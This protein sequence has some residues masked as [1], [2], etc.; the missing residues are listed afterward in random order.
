MDGLVSGPP[1]LLL[2]I[3]LLVI[4]LAYL[5]TP[6]RASPPRAAASARGRYV[7][8]DPE[9]PCTA[10]LLHHYHLGMHLI[11]L[12]PDPLTLRLDP[13]RFVLRAVLLLLLR[14][15]PFSVVL[16]LCIDCPAD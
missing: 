4:K 11:F 10:A 5:F 8:W 14:S 3:L 13:P 9:W 15:A 2:F 1:F 7:S 6:S 12:R 16:L